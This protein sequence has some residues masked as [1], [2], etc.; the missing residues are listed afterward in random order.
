MIQDPRVAAHDAVL[1]DNTTDSVVASGN[2]C[3]EN[4]SECDCSFYDEIAVGEA[5]AAISGNAV[6][7]MCN[8]AMAP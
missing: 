8:W 5:L 3:I 7:L 6:S 4:E 2:T 1:R